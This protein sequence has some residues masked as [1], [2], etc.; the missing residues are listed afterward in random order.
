MAGDVIDFPGLARK[1]ARSGD[2]CEPYFTRAIIENEASINI[3]GT[4]GTM[5][6][7]ICML[8]TSGEWILTLPPPRFEWAYGTVLGALRP[9]ALSKLATALII[10]IATTDH[11]VE[12]WVLT[13]G[14]DHCAL[15]V[16]FD[17]DFVR[18]RQPE[19]MLEEAPAIIRTIFAWFCLGKRELT[20]ICLKQMRSVFG[21]PGRW[22]TFF[23][24]EHDALEVVN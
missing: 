15:S 6:T 5:A 18:I 4:L 13:P 24:P 16:E 11:S 23:V 14:G 9:F 7:R 12:T 1:S 19:P 2:A 21:D 22:P 20:P 8:S 10:S 3:V 17:R